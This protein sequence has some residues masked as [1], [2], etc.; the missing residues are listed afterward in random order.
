MHDPTNATF[1]VQLERDVMHAF[2]SLGGM[3][4]VVHPREG[5]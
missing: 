2:V 1:Y 5:W 3:G 4:L